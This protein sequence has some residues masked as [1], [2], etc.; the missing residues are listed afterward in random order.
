MAAGAIGISCATINEA[1]AMALGIRAGADPQTLY[2]VISE[3]AGSSWM[4]VNVFMAL[5]W[6]ELFLPEEVQPFYALKDRRV[7]RTGYG[8][9]TCRPFVKHGGGVS[10]GHR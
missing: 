8:G 3:S 4:R 7:G 9:S 2:D 1:E 5:S 6:R 10:P